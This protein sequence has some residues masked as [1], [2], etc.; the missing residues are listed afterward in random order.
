MDTQ[1]SYFQLSQDI[2]FCAV[3]GRTIVLDLGA[4]RYAALPAELG[5]VVSRAIGELGQRTALPSDVLHALKRQFGGQR[6]LFD[7]PQRVLVNRPIRSLGWAPTEMAGIGSP[8]LAAVALATISAKLAISRK[9]VR[10]AALHPS[11]FCPSDTSSTRWD[12]IRSIVSVFNKWRGLIPI[13]RRCL[14]DSL[15]LQL[16]L[17][18]VGMRIPL[19]IGVQA[20]PFAAHCWLQIDDIVIDNDLDSVRWFAP[21]RVGSQ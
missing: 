10:A 15:A 6:T 20:N 4:D 5:R 19:V 8:S 21:V 1:H 16:L 3:D 11:R 12:E 17:A 9:G 7:E 2:T 14:V 18:K 13:E